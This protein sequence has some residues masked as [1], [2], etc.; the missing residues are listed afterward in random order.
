MS[1]SPETTF[2]V[3]KK[4][5]LSLLAWLA[6]LWLVRGW[7]GD[8]AYLIVMASLLF[9]IFASLNSRTLWIWEVLATLTLFGLISE[10]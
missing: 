1:T 10:F 7:V 3:W 2:P 9:L 6:I 5:S 8:W 4:A